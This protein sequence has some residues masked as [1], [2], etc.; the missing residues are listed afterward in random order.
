MSCDSNQHAFLTLD[1]NYQFIFSI[2]AQCLWFGLTKIKK[3]YFVCFQ[4]RLSFIDKLQHILF[5]LR[6]ILKKSWRLLGYVLVHACELFRHSSHT[7]TSI[8]LKYRQDN[9][10]NLVEEHPAA[11]HSATLFAT[12]K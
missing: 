8:T 3:T 2:F 9:S 7:T 11:V 1:P 6:P 10:G 5:C 12:F 4:L